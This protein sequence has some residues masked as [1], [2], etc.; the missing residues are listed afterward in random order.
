MLVTW[1]G[2]GLGLGLASHSMLVTC[3]VYRCIYVVC[4][5]GI[6]EDGRQLAERIYAWYVGMLWEAWYLRVVCWHGV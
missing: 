3:M 6:Y 1:L 5:R 2:L 4:R